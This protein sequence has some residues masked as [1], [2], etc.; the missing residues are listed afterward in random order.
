MQEEEQVLQGAMFI[1][2]LV[3]CEVWWSI[4]VERSSE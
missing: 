4:Q 1:W 3:E 2:R